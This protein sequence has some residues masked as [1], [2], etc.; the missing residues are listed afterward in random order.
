MRVL[1]KEHAMTLMRPDVLLRNLAIQTT[2]LESTKQ[3]QERVIRLIPRL[4]AEDPE[5]LAE[6]AAAF[7]W[8]LSIK[9]CLL[10]EISSAALKAHYE[11]LNTAVTKA[12][13]EYLVEQWLYDFAEILKNNTDD[14][15]VDFAARQMIKTVC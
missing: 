1:I 3:Q 4:V 2:V 8:E 15:A 12:G 11:V 9:P 10:P 14:Y 6:S 13:F 5:G 7:L